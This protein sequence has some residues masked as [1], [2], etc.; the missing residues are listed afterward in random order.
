MGRARKKMELAERKGKVLK[1]A[2]VKI[3]KETF[4]L[5]LS[6]GNFLA[7]AQTNF[8]LG[9]HFYDIFRTCPSGARS[10]S[11][12]NRTESRKRTYEVVTV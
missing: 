7:L 8:F 6:R 3:K 12:K 5:S 1:R 10:G 4:L 9:R 2:A 11:S